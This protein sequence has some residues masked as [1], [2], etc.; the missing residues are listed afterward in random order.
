VV[1]FTD[2]IGGDVFRD[3]RVNRLL[4]RLIDLDDFFDLAAEITCQQITNRLRLA[5]LILSNRFLLY[6]F[7]VHLGL[8]GP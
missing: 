6:S 4:V 3:F 2:T 1:L 8:S 7:P 5:T